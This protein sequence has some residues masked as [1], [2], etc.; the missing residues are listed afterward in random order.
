VPSTTLRITQDCENRVTTPYGEP[1]G[2]DPNAIMPQALTNGV[3][4]Q[5]DRVLPV[6][7]VSSS[8][9]IVTVTCSA[10]HGLT[11]NDQVS[12]LGLTSANGFYSVQVPTATVFTFQ[13][14]SPQNPQLTPGV[15]IVTCQV[16]LPRGYTEFPI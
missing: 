3:P 8:G 6:L 15:R 4:T 16:G 2:L 7:S 14:A 11:A 10:V 1:L 5:Y 9:C 13:T 12:V